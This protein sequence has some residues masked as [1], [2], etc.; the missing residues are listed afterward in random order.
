MVAEYTV[1]WSGGK[2]STAALLWALNNGLNFK[3]LY[4]EIAGNTDNMC[5]EY[6]HK[7]A[8]ELG[9]EDRLVHYRAVYKGLGFFEL[10][11]KWGVPLPSYR[12][13]LT[14]LKMRA[15]KLADTDIV[16][17]GLRRSESVLRKKYVQEL[18]YMP[19]A[20]KVSYNPIW[21]WSDVQVRDYLRD[22]GVRLNPCYERFGHGGNCMFC[23]FYNKTQI[24]KTMCDNVWS[25]RII[26]MLRH[27]KNRLMKGEQG[28]KVY[29]R[30]MRYAGQK[31][32]F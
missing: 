1:L 31:T 19:K 30:W 25:S 23:P 6:V 9:I 29:S 10:V 7:L 13:C 22:N 21:N 26:T 18:T 3:V 20:G 11:E 28:R 8:E 14:N 5:N 24:A 4:V 17:S 2:D 27:N 32:L 12:W 15:F 16:V